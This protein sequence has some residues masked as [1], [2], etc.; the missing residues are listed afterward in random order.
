LSE[1]CETLGAATQNGDIYV[2]ASKTFP[3]DDRVALVVIGGLQVTNASL[4][5]LAGNTPDWRLEASPPGASNWER[6]SCLAGSS[7]SNRTRSRGIARSSL[8]ATLA[9]FVRVS[10][11]ERLSVSAAVVRLGDEIA[12]GSARRPAAGSRLAW[13]SASERS[14]RP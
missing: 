1:A 9:F 14:Q 11:A 2:A 10:P 13:A 8:P 6:C 5:G 4:F 3:V 12:P 7:Y